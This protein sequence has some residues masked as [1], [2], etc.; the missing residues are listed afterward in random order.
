MVFVVGLVVC[1][2]G[3]HFH[4]LLVALQAVRFLVLVA[5][6]CVVGAL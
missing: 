1:V 2:V 4:C 3:H 5:L 6:L